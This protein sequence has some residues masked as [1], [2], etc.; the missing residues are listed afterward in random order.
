[1]NSE[2]AYIALERH[3]MYNYSDYF[4]PMLQKRQLLA[5][6][7]R[8]RDMSHS[9]VHKNVIRYLILDGLTDEQILEM[10]PAQRRTYIYLLGD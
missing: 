4:N 10:S 3:T 2:E 6:L 9:Y 7:K 5:D 1:M 8:C